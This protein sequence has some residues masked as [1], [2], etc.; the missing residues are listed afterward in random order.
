MPHLTLRWWILTWIT[1][2]FLGDIWDN[3][4]H[5]SQHDKD[6]LSQNY[7]CLNTSV[8]YKYNCNIAVRNLKHLDSSVIRA[9][10][11]FIVHIKPPAMLE[12]KLLMLC[13]LIFNAWEHSLH[14]IWKLNLNISTNVPLCM[15]LSYYV[16][17]KFYFHVATSTGKSVTKYASH[18]HI[19]IFLNRLRIFSRNKITLW[20]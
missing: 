15:F 6:P 9:G 16:Q 11:T 7:Q 19:N 12:S 13:N 10:L 17:M 14:G 1:S 8:T 20:I 5:R 18:T 2:T 4:Q 3:P